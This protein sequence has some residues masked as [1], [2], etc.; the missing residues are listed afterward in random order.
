MSELSTHS[1]SDICLQV[2]TQLAE[3]AGAIEAELADVQRLATVLKRL[4]HLVAPPNNKCAPL[5]VFFFPFVFLPKYNSQSVRSAGCLF[6]TQLFV[7]L[8][9]KCNAVLLASVSIVSVFVAST[10]MVVAG[11]CSATCQQ[12]AQ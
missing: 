9:C 8:C 11:C 5:L 1:S 3:A 10:Q 4:H 6:R 12:A 7:R 2:L